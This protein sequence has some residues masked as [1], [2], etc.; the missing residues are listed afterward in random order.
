VAGAGKTTPC[1]Q[2]FLVTQGATPF[3]VLAHSCS[4]T[5]SILFYTLH[6]LYP[7][8]ILFLSILLNLPQ[9]I[10]FFSV[11]PFYFL[12]GIK[13]KFFFIHGI[14]LPK[15]RLMEMITNIKEDGD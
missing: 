6:L 14:K 10:L 1:F 2:S 5:T 12:N 4:F 15:E 7:S 11:P 3:S 8:F 13:N 9:D